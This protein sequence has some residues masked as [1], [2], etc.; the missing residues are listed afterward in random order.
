M[1]QH[2]AGD[3]ARRT[4]RPV[5]HPPHRRADRTALRAG[6]QG[7]EL[8]PAPLFLVL[9]AADRIDAGRSR[10]LPA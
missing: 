4:G 5:R 3:G 2:L 9:P 8:F 10:A 6:R 1:R 7:R